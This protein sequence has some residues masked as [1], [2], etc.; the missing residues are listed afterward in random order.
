MAHK[1]MHVT[2]DMRIGGT[3]MVIKNIIEG[4]NELYPDF[5]FSLFCIEQP[6]GPWGQMLQ[7]HGIKIDSYCRRPGFDWRLIRAVRHSIVFHNIDVVHCHQYTPWVY[8]LIAAL[9]TRAKVIFTEHGR[10]YPDVRSWKRLLLNPLFSRCTSVITS[11]SKATKN[12]L[13]QFEG[14][15]EKDIVVVYNGIIPLKPNDDEVCKIRKHLGVGTDQF[16]FGTVARFDPI[17]NQAMMIRAF[18]NVASEN[19]DVCLLLVGD[20]EER[21]RLQSLADTLAVADRVFFTGYISEP[22]NFIAAMD[23]FLLSSLSEGASMTLLEAM[24][25]GKPC[26][27][28]N[29]GGNSEII[30]NK[31]NGLVTP[32]DDVSA[33]SAAMKLLSQDSALRDTCSAGARLR[34]DKMFAIKH[35]V[36]HY[37]DLYE[38]LD[39]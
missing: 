30:V 21:N 32:N 29:A 24:S 11:I 31:E 8:G 17:K 28:T 34:F 27:V 16:V 20:G 36:N 9:G 39:R 6:V 22:V 18:A 5:E 33:F 12:A 15:K 26:I 23:I 19:P 7:G 38:G 4:F 1:I 35:M 3:E 25:L 2:Y 37:R 14:I 13:V 10:F